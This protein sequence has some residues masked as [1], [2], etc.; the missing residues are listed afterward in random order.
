MT[1]HIRKQVRVAAKALIVT[2]ADFGSRVY[3][4]RV[5]PI[6]TRDLPMASIEV[7]MEKANVRTQGFPRVAARNQKL[8]VKVYCAATANQLDV[9]DAL[10]LLVEQALF[11][12]ESAIRLGGVVQNIT[13]VGVTIDHKITGELTWAVATHEIDVT[14]AVLES[15][16]SAE[17]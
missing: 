7:L 1:T 4:Q 15:N 3:D 5:I 11:G 9:L 13:L 14:V 6:T 17:L 2:V 10:C 12:S 8:I 16:P